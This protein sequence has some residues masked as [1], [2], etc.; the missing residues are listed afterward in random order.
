MQRPQRGAAYSKAQ[1]QVYNACSVQQWQLVQVC[2]LP[3]WHL[4]HAAAALQLI[5]CLT[6]LHRSHRIVSVIE[7]SSTMVQAY[8]PAP[9]EFFRPA[10]L[11]D[12]ERIAELEV[13]IFRASKS[14]NN[15]VG[16]P[17]RCQHSRRRVPFPLS[18]PLNNVA[19]PCVHYPR[20]RATLQTK[21]Q[22]ERDWSTA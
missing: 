1:Q 7:R 16:T 22:A 10:T 19:L 12:L 20:R 6:R 21:Q 15:C 14:A 13:K 11:E 18:P 3:T 8:E 9:A 5:E 2:R 17:R 4:T